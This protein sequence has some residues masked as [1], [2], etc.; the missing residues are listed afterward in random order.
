MR[1]VHFSSRHVPI[2]RDEE[3]ETRFPLG[4]FEK[5]KGLWV[6]DE[7]SELGWHAWC[8]A[9]Q[10]GLDRF[11]HTHDVYLKENSNILLL[12]SAEDIDM[13][14]EQYKTD[15]SDI[16]GENARY[17]DG[18]NWHRVA[19]NHN[20]ILITPYIWERRLERNTSWY[21]GWDCASGCIWRASEAV[22]RIVL[23]ENEFS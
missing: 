9:E 10:F 23:R 22:D 7:D 5:P 1:L 3:Q 15:L 13:F 8:K 14:T 6:S 20:G 4:S 17:F 19:E 2:I 11:T 16:Y 18:I 12:Q 21:Y